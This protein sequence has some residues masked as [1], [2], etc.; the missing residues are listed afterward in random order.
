MCSQVIY[1]EKGCILE[2]ILCGLTA[3]YTVSY[4]Q[5]VKGTYR[6]IWYKGKLHGLVSDKTTHA[7]NILVIGR[8]IFVG[9]QRWW[10]DHL[11]CHCQAVCKDV[12][13]GDSQ[14]K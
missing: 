8:G 14:T 7:Q 6:T 1:K 5:G 9:Y 11:D 12:Y 3:V 2:G 4:A 10:K 13:Q